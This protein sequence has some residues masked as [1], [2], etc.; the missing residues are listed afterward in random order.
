MP[1]HTRKEINIEPIDIIRI[2][3][4]KPGKYIKDIYTKIEKNILHN[5][6][7]NKKCD[8]IK[9]IENIKE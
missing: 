6:L 3:D 8:I 9:Y 5:R 2:F 1:I 4:K 7:N